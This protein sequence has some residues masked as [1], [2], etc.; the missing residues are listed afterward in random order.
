[1]RLPSR[2]IASGKWFVSSIWSPSGNA[3]LKR[4]GEPPASASS[5]QLP[6][7]SFQLPAA[8]RGG[9]CDARPRCRR[10]A[11]RAAQNAAVAPGRQP[12]ARTVRSLPAPVARRRWSSGACA[13]PSRGSGAAGVESTEACRRKRLPVRLALEHGREYFRHVI[14]IERAS[15]GQHL[16]E[17]DAERPDVGAPVHWPAL[18]PAPAPCRRR[19][20]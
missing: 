7:P 8:H 6:S 2:E 19:C 14:A 10:S 16:V 13:D 17:D 5:C 18:S 11:R 15:A 1:M 3:I 9:G 4:I 20:R 12:T